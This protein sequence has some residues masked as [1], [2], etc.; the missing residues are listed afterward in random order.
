[1][2]STVTHRYVGVT[3]E[4]TQCDQC[5]RTELRSTV[6][7][8]TL[9]ADGNDDAV[10]YYGSSCAARALGRTGRGQ[11]R[12]VLDEARSARYRLA[13]EVE[14]ARTCV[15]RYVDVEGDDRKL[16]WRFY[17]NHA[18][19]RWIGSTS[20]EELLVMVKDLLASKRVIIADAELIGL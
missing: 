6:V 3:D 15:A 19:A 4:S 11:A 13:G 7:L 20:P 9:D 5:G 2:A 14:A 10:V 18:N 8:Y 16:R 12:K 17:E 1:M